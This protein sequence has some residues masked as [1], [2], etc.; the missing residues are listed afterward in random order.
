MQD[1]HHFLNNMQFNNFMFHV[2]KINVNT[3]IL[4]TRQVLP[5]AVCFSIE[6]CLYLCDV[7]IEQA[8]EGKVLDFMIMNIIKL[9]S[10]VIFWPP[11][12]RG[13]DKSLA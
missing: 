10:F 2:Q 4:Y 9:K 13:A 6:Q 3:I 8:N 5:L 1:I 12:Y 11:M 7:N